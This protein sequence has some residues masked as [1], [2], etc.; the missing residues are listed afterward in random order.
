MSVS[1]PSVVF[2]V[3]CCVALCSAVPV[4]EQ[5]SNDEDV[6]KLV[7]EQES[8]SQET[9]VET[10][11]ETHLKQ[12]EDLAE[13]HK[14]QVE[15]L[16]ATHSKAMETL[17]ETHKKQIDALE[18]VEEKQIS[19]QFFNNCPYRFCSSELCQVEPGLVDCNGCTA[20][21]QSNYGTNFGNF[22]TFG[23]F[24]PSPSTSY[25]FFTSYSGF[26]NRFPFFKADALTNAEREAE[27]EALTEGQGEPDEVLTNTQEEQPV[28]AQ[29][30]AEEEPK[31][32]A[33]TKAVEEQ[34]EEPKDEA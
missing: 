21:C 24:G 11:K 31:T 12:V 27:T 22:G 9:L 26:P 25:P 17:K 16:T 23:T 1:S 5:A 14:K 7:E 4:Q 10:L 20:F 28:E 32:E 34:K 3:M 13:T 15:D 33:Q 29:A 30:K 19:K 8:E 18:K 6:P 2:V